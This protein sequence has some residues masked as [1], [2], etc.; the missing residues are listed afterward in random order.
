[1]DRIKLICPV[2]GSHDVEIK[3]GAFFCLACETYFYDSS[4][5]KESLSEEDVKRISSFERAEEYLRLS[6]PR[7]FEAEDR[8]RKLIKEYPSISA[9]YWGALRA[10]Y[11]IK[12]EIDIDGKA[13]PV[14]YKSKYQNIKEDSLYELAIKNSETD[15]IKDKY[16]L[17]ASRIEETWKKWAEAT[18]KYKY[19]VFLSFKVTDENGI[20]TEDKK[21]MGE[22]YTYLTGK[23]YKVF[24]SPVSMREFTGKPYYDAY[25]FNALEKA[26]VLIVYGS[27]SEYFTSTWVE[28]EWSRYLLQ[29]ANNEKLYDSLILAHKGF[30]PSKELPAKLAKRESYDASSFT[31][32]PDIHR[33]VNKV[34]SE[35][36]P[37]KGKGKKGVLSHI[38]IEPN[39]NFKKE[40]EKDLDLYDVEEN[41]GEKH[42]NNVNDIHLREIK[43]NKDY[44]VKYTNQDKLETALFCLENNNYHEA[45][46]LFK[47]IFND[48]KENLVGVIGLLSSIVCDSSLYK[49]VILN[50]DNEFIYNKRFSDYASINIAKHLG[51][52]NHALNIV[53]NK[54]EAV[55]LLKY[56]LNAV[57]QLVGTN[58]R[59][60]KFSKDVYILSKLILSY[61]T[62]ARDDYKK[63]FTIH[64]HDF[65]SELE[66]KQFEE[67]ALNICQTYIDEQIDEYLSLLEV[68]VIGY[69]NNKNYKEA[70]KWNGRKLE[71]YPGDP[72]ANI[73]GVYLSVNVKNHEAFYRLHFSKHIAPKV[74][75]TMEKCIKKA[76]KKDVDKLLEDIIDIVITSADG[77]NNN[78]YRNGV[79]YLAFLAKYKFSQKTHVY[80]ELIKNKLY[81]AVGKNRMELVYLLAK[82]VSFEEEQKNI[83]AILSISSILRDKRMFLDA[84]KINEI[85]IKRFGYYSSLLFEILLSKIKY[86]DYNVVMIS[87]NKKYFNK[88]EL[89]TVLMYSSKEE[90]EKCLNVI[91]DLLESSLY[92]IKVP[93]RFKE[94]ILA[95]DLTL[96]YIDM[97]DDKLLALFDKLALSCLEHSEFDLAYHYALLSLD[98]N[99]NY[100]VNANYIFLMTKIKCS[101]D[102]AWKHSS[103]F[104]RDLLEYKNLIIACKND[105]KKINYY[106]SLAERNDEL[107]GKKRRNRRYK[108]DIKR[109]E[110]YNTRQEQKKVANVQRFHKNRNGDISKMEILSKFNIYRALKVMGIILIIGGLIS[111]IGHG[112]IVSTILASITI[113]V[114]I[115]AG[116][117]ALFK[118]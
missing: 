56:L 7:F 25:I 57:M 65:I 36:K 12:Y 32:F 44:T 6:P 78:L 94:V 71:A 4:I 26:N 95:Y 52:I 40:V 107:S 10:K 81:N 28:N 109:A 27:K 102:E 62:D 90:Q 104:S 84:I 100:N 47:D 103:R 86:D 5:K 53:N 33:L 93:H 87:W 48:D 69:E 75:K 29:I 50:K 45:E 49:Q 3:D 59:G 99:P 74:I 9:A 110:R 118:K 21:V 1:M 51:L 38:H 43:V 79:D 92:K 37:N 85:G 117:I 114:A 115:L 58:H 18:K 42:V 64:T 67:I 13:I 39:K 24:Y 108:K 83:N 15:N 19:D 116:L 89:E 54:Y 73:R 46:S 22:L 35:S 17:E 66:P 98:K 8:Y 76:N 72:L 14:C 55:N 61:D 16:V 91:F 106:S 112:P 11:G 96:R 23:G 80:D 30:N 111:F 70:L 68:I 60:Q 34:L 41:K 88:K 63:I 20:D 31:F 97:E 101:D 82:T 113:A 77:G 105:Y 2:C